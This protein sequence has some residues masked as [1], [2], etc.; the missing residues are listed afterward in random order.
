MTLYEIFCTKPSLE[1]L[2]AD[3]CVVLLTQPDIEKS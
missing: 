3:S 1:L 2:Q